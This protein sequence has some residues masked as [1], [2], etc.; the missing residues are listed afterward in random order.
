MTTTIAPTFYFKF[1]FESMTAQELKEHAGILRRKIISESKYLKS[2]K[3]LPLK[4][5]TEKHIIAFTHEFFDVV[6]TLAD[7]AVI[8]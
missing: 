7:R 6:S 2:L 8:A 3:S 5:A 1:E 4:D